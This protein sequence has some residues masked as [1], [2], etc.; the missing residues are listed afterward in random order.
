MLQYKACRSSIMFEDALDLD[1]M[2]HLVDKMSETEYP[3][4]CA[5]GRPTVRHLLGKPTK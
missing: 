3:W 4:T 1:G 5:H 2:R